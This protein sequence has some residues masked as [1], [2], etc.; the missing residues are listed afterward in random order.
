MNSFS[1]LINL[2]PL[3]QQKNATQALSNSCR[4][5]WAN[6]TLQ[7]MTLILRDSPELKTHTNLTTSRPQTSHNAED[8]VTPVL[9]PFKTKYRKYINVSLWTC[10]DSHVWQTQ[11][12][13]K[14]TALYLRHPYIPILSTTHGPLT[15]SQLCRAAWLQSELQFLSLWIM[16][17]WDSSPASHISSKAQSLIQ[18]LSGSQIHL[19]SFLLPPPERKALKLWWPLIPTESYCGLYDRVAQAKCRPQRIIWC[20]LPRGAYVSCSYTPQTQQCRPPPLCF[21]LLS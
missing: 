18:S 15:Y 14:N 19:C 20:G 12:S 3:W 9:S 7:E 1:L 21:S 4:F 2:F 8:H 13:G 6:K 17:G 11:F 16:L 10:E 5:N